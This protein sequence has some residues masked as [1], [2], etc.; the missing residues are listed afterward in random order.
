MALTVQKV[1]AWISRFLPIVEVLYGFVSGAGCA[2][3]G[4]LGVSGSA[5]V[6]APT[7]NSRAASRASKRISARI[8]WLGSSGDVGKFDSDSDMGPN[9]LRVIREPEGVD[10]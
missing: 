7:R 6:P 9:L 3:A 10:Q 2:G 4:F 5:E 1:W 8:A